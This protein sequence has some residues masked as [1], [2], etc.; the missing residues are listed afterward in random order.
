VVYL[1]RRL[2]IAAI[3]SDGAITVS[4][5]RLR[6][7]AIITLITPMIWTEA[8]RLVTR[9]DLYLSPSGLP[10][11]FLGEAACAPLLFRHFVPTYFIFGALE[12]AAEMHFYGVHEDVVCINHLLHG[13]HIFV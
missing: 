8:V 2:S 5:Y 10:L 9:S 11:A 13:H 6:S 3:D 1:F 4:L 12:T 7:Y